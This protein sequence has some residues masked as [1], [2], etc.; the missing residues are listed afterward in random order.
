MF[1]YKHMKI[2]SPAFRRWQRVRRLGKHRFVFL[3]SAL[4]SVLLLVMVVALWLSARISY[5]ESVPLIAM[6]LVVLLVPGHFRRVWE[7]NEALYHTALRREARKKDMENFRDEAIV[8]AARR[9]GE[10]SLADSH[11]ESDRPKG[12]SRD[13]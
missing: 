9:I 8:A 13:E 12:K 7:S 3:F 11:P 10:N 2:D 5:L 6:L 1:N 4:Q